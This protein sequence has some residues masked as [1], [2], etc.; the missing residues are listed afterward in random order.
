MNTFAAMKSDG[1]DAVVLIPDIFFYVNREQIS[2][3][4]RQFRI[5]LMSCTTAYVEVG[6]RS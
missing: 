3:M 2:R 1:M 5:P 4:A 6:A